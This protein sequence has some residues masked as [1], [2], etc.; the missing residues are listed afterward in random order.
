MQWP[1]S[2]GDCLSYWHPSWSKRSRS[3]HHQPIASLCKKAWPNTWWKWH[4]QTHSWQCDPW[5]AVSTRPTPTLCQYCS[6]TLTW[7]RSCVHW[8]GKLFPHGVWKTLKIE[9]C[10]WAVLS[11]HLGWHLV[12]LTSFC[13]SPLSP[14]AHCMLWSSCWLWSP[15]SW[16]Q[17][18]RCPSSACSWWWLSMPEQHQG[19]AGSFPWVCG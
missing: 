19:S 10:A 2:C 16:S 17:S 6:Q 18:C 9:T 3:K 1:T 7:C 13:L 15:S 5:F 14:Y 8:E 4:T 12:L 11:F